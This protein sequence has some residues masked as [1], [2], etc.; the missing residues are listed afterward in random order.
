MRIVLEQQVSLASG[1]A[2][3]DRLRFACGG[4]VNA[5]RIRLLDDAS[6][7]GC[8]LSRQKVR[9]VGQLA[10]DV[11]ARRFSVAGL[12]RLS[13]DE[14]RQQI[15]SRLG[16]G[17]WTADIYLMMALGREDILP[18]GDLAL[19][20]GLEELDGVVYRQGKQTTANVTERAEIWRPYR[21]L[22]TKLIWANYLD[23]R[24]K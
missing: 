22:G 13:D 6:L 2:T 23:R 7:A 9:Y 18:V 1:K 21:S 14:A 12:A 24:R 17:D 8:G 19:V 10:R 16:L 3:F 11:Q 4:A 20:T 5:S 15:T